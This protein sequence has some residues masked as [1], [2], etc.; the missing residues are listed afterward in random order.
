MLELTHKDFKIL[1]ICPRDLK[2]F[3]AI[4]VRDRWKIPSR[5]K[6]CQKKKI[7]I[8]QSCQDNGILLSNNNGQTD[9]HN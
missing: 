3:K 6:N 9:V 5:S 1:Q 8:I 2:F 7:I 4:I